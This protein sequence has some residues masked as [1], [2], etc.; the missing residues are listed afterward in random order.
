M[1]N[2]NQIKTHFDSNVIIFFALLFVFSCGLLAFKNN[3]KEAC[4]VEDFNIEGLALEEGELLTFSDNSDNSYAW[5]WYFGD[6]SDISYKSKVTHVFKKSGIYKVKLL[7][8]NSCVLEKNIK[9]SPRSLAVVEKK[10]DVDFFVPSKVYQGQKIKFSDKTENGTTW[11]WRFGET[12]V[13]D[14]KKKNPTYAY[15]TAG[16]KT[17][18]IVVNGDK[19]NVKFKDIVVVMPEVKKTI[20]RIKVNNKVENVPEVVVEVLETPKVEVI[21]AI[22]EVELTELIY[23]ISEGKLSYESFKNNFCL[24]KLPLVQVND[25][26]KYISLKEFYDLV[27]DKKIKIKEVKINKEKNKCIVLVLVYYKQKTFF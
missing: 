19:K 26:A 25:V 23:I 17:V 16:V 21:K 11:E 7:I 27:V 13:V 3:E 2:Q 5:R 15:K 14:S 9:I 20:K 18:S 4:L 24:D 8:N 6:G 10:L 22:N 1:N 12:D